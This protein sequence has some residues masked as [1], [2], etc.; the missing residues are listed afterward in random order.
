MKCSE[1]SKSLC[2]KLFTNFLTDEDDKVVL[3]TT[4]QT[5]RTMVD[6]WNFNKD[7]FQ[8]FLTENVHLLL[9]KILPSVSLTETRLYVLNT[10][11]DI[12]IQTKP[13]ISRDLLVEILQI[14]PN[15]WE[16]ATNNASEAIL[17]NALLRLLRNL[18]SS[19]GSQSHLTWDI[20]IPVVALACDP[21]SM[22]YQLLS[23]DGYELWGMLLQNFH[24]TIKSLTISSLNWCHF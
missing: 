19:L 6:D 3:L 13:L 12:I 22:Q 8:P 15:L 21:S 4:V 11:S 10:L 1:E 20:A 23:E 9:R 16:I 5:V 14:I 17:A 2:Y 24:P 7:T 18:V